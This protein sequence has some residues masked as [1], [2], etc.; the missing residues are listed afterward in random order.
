MNTGFYGKLLCLSRMTI[1][2]A[3]SYAHVVP[4]SWNYAQKQTF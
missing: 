1:L 2:Q 3:I 4:F